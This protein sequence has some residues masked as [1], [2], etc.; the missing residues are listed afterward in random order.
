MDECRVESVDST[1]VQYSWESEARLNLTLHQEYSCPLP[2]CIQ[3]VQM[4][5]EWVKE[6]GV[7]RSRALHVGCGTGR[8]T[9]ELSQL[10]NNVSGIWLIFV[11]V[12]VY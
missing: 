12:N 7:A 9:V 11:S 10:F 5:K 1:N 4:V 6:Q 2:P 3:L 8:V